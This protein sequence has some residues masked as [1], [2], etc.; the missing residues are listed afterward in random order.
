MADYPITINKPEDLQPLFLRLRGRTNYP[1]TVTIKDGEQKRTERQNRLQQRWYSDASSQGDQESSE[2]R[3]YCKLHFGVVILREE[4]EEFRIKY[5]R[6]IRPLT[7][8]LKLELMLPPFDFPVTRLMSV[9]QKS[10]F[11]DKVWNHFTSQGMQLTDPS[12]L[13]LEDYGR[14]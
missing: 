1:Y 11:M 4:N 8:E 7:Y 5:D 9:K 3:A 6:V 10:K 12:L 14:R 13:G 2:Y